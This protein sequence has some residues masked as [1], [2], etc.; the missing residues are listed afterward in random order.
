MAANRTDTVLRPYPIGHHRASAANR[1]KDSAWEFNWEPEGSAGPEGS[2]TLNCDRFGRH[3]LPSR[4]IQMTA[5]RSAIPSCDSTRLVITERL[6]RTTELRL[7]AQQK[8][9]DS[10]DSEES[11]RLGCDRPG[12]CQHLPGVRVSGHLSRRRVCFYRTARPT[13]PPLLPLAWASPDKINTHPCE[14]LPTGRHSVETSL[15]SLGPRTLLPPDP[16]RRS[17]GALPALEP[18]LTVAHAFS[19]MTTRLDF[20]S[21]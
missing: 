11:A 2:T 19:H 17:R 20:N 7:G 4:R 21:Y 3:P 14:R 9:E 10:A 16:S 8:P 5:D 6:W 18:E 12:G 15:V 1:W 13:L